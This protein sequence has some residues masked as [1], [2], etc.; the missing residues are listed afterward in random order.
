M[1]N[2]QPNET[3]VEHMTTINQVDE[4]TFSMHELY[5]AFLTDKDNADLAWVELNSDR[6]LAKLQELADLME[7][8][9][10]IDLRKDMYV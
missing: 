10:L 6:K 2:S 3:L 1:H 8:S 9:T 5:T 7:I 4:L